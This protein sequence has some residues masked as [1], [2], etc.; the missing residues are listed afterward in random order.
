M[1][2]LFACYAFCRQFSSLRDPIHNLHVQ[3]LLLENAP[4]LDEA[5]RMAIAHALLAAD[6]PRPL[7]TKEVHVI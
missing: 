4:Q 1:W 6:S 2:C 3:Q 7:P 5:D